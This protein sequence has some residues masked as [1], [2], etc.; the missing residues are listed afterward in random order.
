MSLGYR[1][2]RAAVNGF[3]TPREDVESFARF[4]GF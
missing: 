4:V 2:E 3:E 1:D